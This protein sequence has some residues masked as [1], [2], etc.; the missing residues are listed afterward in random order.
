[1]IQKHFD[2]AIELNPT[3]PTSRHLLGLWSFAFADL[4]WYPPL[5]TLYPCL[6]IPVCCLSV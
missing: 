1:M 6:L 5:S 2:R 4:A 3:D